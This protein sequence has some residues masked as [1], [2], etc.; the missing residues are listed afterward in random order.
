MRMSG[1]ILKRKSA[2]GIRPLPW[3]PLV[4][5]AL[6]LSGSAQE[7]VLREGIQVGLGL[8]NTTLRMT[9]RAEVRLSGTG[10][11]LPGSVVQLDSPD[12]GL[13]LSGVSPSQAASTLLSRV[14]VRGTAAV[15]G[16]NV[17][18]AQFGQGSA[19]L[20]HG[21]GF[22]PLEVFAGR[23]F[24]GPATRLLPH[25]DHGSNALAPLG[26]TLGSFR[27][28]RGY[29]ATFAQQASGNGVSR[30]YVAQDGDLEIGR[31]PAALENNVQFIRVFPWRWAA[32]KGIAGNI[33]SNLDVDWLY[34]WNLD[35]N[36]PLDWEY[37]PIRQTRWWPPLNQDWAARGA[38]HLLG[39]NEPDRPDQANLAVGDAIWS[40]PDLLATGLRVG[41]PAVSDGGLSWLYDFMDQA[42]A[43]G[44]RVDFVPVHYYRCYGNVG[45]PAGTANQFYNFLK[46]IHDRVQRPLWVTEWNNGANWTTCSDPTFAQQQAAVAAILDMLDS[47]PF[48]ER[49]ALYNWVE[50]VR[51]VKWD[52]GSLTSA[53]TTYRDQAAP[54]AYRQEVPDP[55]TSGS[56][57]YNFEGDGR[58]HW[59]SGRDALLVG[60][61]TFPQGRHGRAVA[62]NGMTDYLQLPAGT[63]DSTDFTFVAWVFWNGGEDWQR[64]VD[65]GEDSNRY[66]F[67][68]PRTSGGN[69]RFAIKNGGSEQQ[70]NAPALA[71]RTWTHLAVTLAGSTG[72]LYVNG[73]PVATNT[74]LSLNP[75]DIPLRFNYL[76]RSRFS[77]DPLFS[78]RLDEVR[79]S[80]SALT[81]AQVLSL[82]TTAPPQFTA[83]PLEKP[84]APA[85]QPY[86]QS[87]AGDVTGGSGT[88]TFTL[89]DG[90]AWLT[91]STNGILSGTPAASDGGPNRFLV[92]VADS[93]GVSHAATLVV[94]VTPCSVAIQDGADDAEEAADGTLSLASTDLELVRDGAAG[95]QLVGLRFPDLPIPQGALITNATLQFT[96]D[97]AQSE[98]TSLQISA[99]AAD[100]AAPF[101]GTAGNLGGRPR[102][103][104]SVPWQPPAWSSAGEAG[105][106]QQTPNLAGLVQ[107]VISRPGWAPGHALALFLRGTGH[108]TADSADKAGGSSPRLTVHYAMPTPQRTFTA[109]INGGANDAEQAASGA[110]TL[111]STDLEL[112]EDGAAGSQL[113]GLRFDS[114]PLPN[115]AALAGAF[116]QFTADEPQTNATALTLRAQA[117]DQAAVFTTNANQVGSRPLTAASVAWTP[118]PWD[119]VGERSSR[120]RSPDLSPLLREVSARPG[121][122]PG[123]ALALV[124]QGTGHRTAEAADKAGAQPAALEVAYWNELP[125]GTY[126]RWA[127][128]RPGLGDP[129]GDP[130]HDGYSNLMEYALG[131]DPAVPSPQAL[132]LAHQGTILSLTFR[133][134]SEVLD[135]KYSVEWASDPGAFNWNTNSVF[136]Q[137]IADDGATRTLQSLLP[138]GTN[139]RFLRL[140]VTLP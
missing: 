37:V 86:T 38:T 45:D 98:A 73:L 12:A 29:L 137:I 9:G 90:P 93:L 83:Q 56:A 23:H 94:P 74:A 26:G 104:L 72:K 62:L 107:E 59:G 85:G 77:A 10:D 123:N 68:S 61:P 80:G 100:D 41:A 117:A 113:V 4:L 89:V 71:L 11:P 49:Y 33:E 22:A 7:V 91:L 51:R 111:N 76:G 3:L 60:A 96:A 44:L 16:S 92:R 42:D 66:L 82:A 134:P 116:L 2:K 54:L 75:S 112:V 15:R 43:A 48:V 131:L 110:V 78:G 136:T 128:A 127:A 57:R 130:D 139:R 55:G 63:G 97:E 8:T 105:P 120:Q 58:D 99:E 69:L 67:L 132:Q 126:A 108:R 13:F 124:I 24:T 20:P 103:T 114:L 36:S 28:Q 138:T 18:V 17:R 87:L 47:T 32:K 84:A 129:S 118:A 79:F 52:D 14:R 46:G 81:D 19:I 50:D 5:A 140:K 95:D 34:N 6:T 125:R 21:P 135:V 119:L 106:A 88:R 35:R 121:W 133:R 122:T 64:I 1:A 40:W 30:C 53:G 109:L 31:L 39:Y 101:A 25:A 102:T 65:L 70:L 27:L 115:G